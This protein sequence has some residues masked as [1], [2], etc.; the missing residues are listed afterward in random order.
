MKIELLNLIE[1]KVG[2]SF[3]LIGRGKYFMNRTL[4]VQILKSTINKS[5]LMRLKSLC[6]TKDRIIWTKQQ[7]T[8]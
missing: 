4:L 2:N 1:E 7:P 3:G 5:D 6:T 8:V